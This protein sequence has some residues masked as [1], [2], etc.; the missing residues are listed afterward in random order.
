M[1]IVRREH[2]GNFTIVANTIFREAD[3]SFEAM[4]VAAY[5][6]SKPDH[7][8]VHLR[9]LA[10]AGGI[11]RDK[12]QRIARELIEAGL[13]ERRQCHNPESGAFDGVEYI[14]RDTPEP[15]NPATVGSPQP[16]LPEP[17]LPESDNP[18][19]VVSTDSEI[20]LI[21]SKE[22]EGAG[23]DS[24]EGD[25][26]AP[27]GQDSAKRW[28]RLKLTYPHAIAD[29]L[30]RSEKLFMAAALADQVAILDAV[31]RLIA[32]LDTPQEN[33]RK[34]KRIRLQDFIN[35]RG[36][37]IVPEPPA[38]P[39]GDTPDAPTDKGFASF[40]F[41]D[42]GWWALIWRAFNAGQFRNVH[43]RLSP[44][45]MS[46]SVMVKSADA[47]TE[48][49]LAA[50]RRVPPDAPEFAAWAEHVKATFAARDLFVELPKPDRAPYVWIPAD[51]P[52]APG[53][54]NSEIEEVMG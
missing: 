30:P 3:L 7:W 14:M 33:G 42:Q 44:S 28:R 32:Y 54:S 49:E 20:K 15:E 4:G 18:V 22:R 27:S 46:R 24:G 16:D 1:T 17:G 31:P 13:L 45:L 25:P 8:N 12:M 50:L 37:E 29:E 40:G 34:P 26:I 39:V 35:Q 36:W 5:L 6:L 9:Q 19:A 2:N 23:E 48:D 53:P 10:K 21:Q 47:P 11:G 52:P 38:E 51:P 43:A 41:A